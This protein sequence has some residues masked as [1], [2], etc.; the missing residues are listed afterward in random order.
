DADLAIGDFTDLEAIGRGGMGLVFKAYEPKL[1]RTVAIKVLRREIASDARALA[2]FRQEAQL[3]AKLNHP[4][5][6][7]IH[8]LG[9]DHGREYRVM[10]Y[11][12]GTS[13]SAKLKLGERLSAATAVS[14]MK[15]CLMALQ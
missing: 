4:H 3:A 12:E 8:R 5:V 6:V 11:V 13:L 7:P 9:T 14:M 2:R 1:D 15:Q 10:Q